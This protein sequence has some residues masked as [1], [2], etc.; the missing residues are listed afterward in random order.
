MTLKKKKKR[1][2][3]Y[4]QYWPND[5]LNGDWWHHEVISDSLNGIIECNQ[6]LSQFIMISPGYQWLTHMNDTIK[7][8]ISLWVTS[9]SE[10]WLTDW[11]H[12]I[13]KWHHNAISL[14]PSDSLDDVGVPLRLLVDDLLQAEP[15]AVHENSTNRQK[16][17]KK[18]SAS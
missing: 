10:H 1:N 2:W 14:S 6:W 7:K 3:R 15:K 8:S 12:Q 11:H 5:S 13:I 9:L 4:Q 18:R 17:T 16:Q